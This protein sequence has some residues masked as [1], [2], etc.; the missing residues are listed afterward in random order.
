MRVTKFFTLTLLAAAL[1]SSAPACVAP[2]EPTCDVN[3]TRDPRLSPNYGGYVLIV[4]SDVPREKVGPILDAAAEWVA[5]C[6]GAFVIGAGFADFDP[7]QRPT[8]GQVRL[9][10][11]P[12][13]SGGS[14]IGVTSWWADPSGR[15]T[16]AVV[17]IQDDLDRRTHYLVALHELGHAVGVPHSTGPEPSVMTPVVTDAG[18]HPTCRD[19]REL[20]AIWA[21]DPRC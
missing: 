5:A 3:V 1:A 21:C 10:L 9:F 2:T 13:A 12:N 6:D 17:W 19:R 15:P 16:S 14:A 20:C 18:D 7:T 8:D 11:G 4:R